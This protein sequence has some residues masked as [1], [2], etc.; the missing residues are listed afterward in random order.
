MHTTIPNSQV[1][2]AWNESTVTLIGYDATGFK[3]TATLTDGLFSLTLYVDLWM[4]T[5]AAKKWK[6]L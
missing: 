5:Q 3:T 2:E 1:A 4:D 6:F